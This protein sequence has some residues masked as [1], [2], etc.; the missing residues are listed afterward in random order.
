MANAKS[1]KGTAKNSVKK[2]RIRRQPEELLKEIK[3]RETRLEA[4]L[5]RK[6][7]KMYQELGASIAKIADF[8]FSDLSIKEKEDIINKSKSAEPIVFD[9]IRKAAENIR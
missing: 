6:Y 4:K 5:V 1:Q 3:E 7:G 9:I 2:K 8:D